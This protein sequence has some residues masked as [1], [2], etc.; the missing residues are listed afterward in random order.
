MS[1]FAAGHDY[2]ELSL[3]DTAGSIEVGDYVWIG[4]RSVVLGGVKI[5]EGA[6][7]GAGSVVTRD[8][9]PYTVAAG[10]PAK[11]IKMRE[12]KGSKESRGQI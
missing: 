4:G 8:I 1:F 7:I 9:P 3:P 2:T 6:V 5:G 11:V 12:L 10:V